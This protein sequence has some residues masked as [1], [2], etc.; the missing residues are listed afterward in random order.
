MLV[1]DLLD[2]CRSEALSD[3]GRDLNVSL[4]Q[5]ASTLAQS[6]GIESYTFA[7]D[8]E[9]VIVAWPMTVLCASHVVRVASLGDDMGEIRG[10]LVYL[11]DFKKDVFEH[12]APSAAM[13]QAPL[14]F[15]G[16]VRDF[17]VARFVKMLSATTAD[18]NAF[19][20]TASATSSA[21]GVAAWASTCDAK[22][23]V[24]M[25][26][27]EE[28]EK[29]HS[30]AALWRKHKN[31]ANEKVAMVDDHIAALNDGVSHC[32]S[33]ADAK[34]AEAGLRMTLASESARD[35]ETARKLE[36]G[37]SCAQVV[38]RRRVAR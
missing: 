7:L 26:K 10:A 8:A 20:A 16:C 9:K 14:R 38:G 6:F 21:L 30:F 23:A 2:A 17:F 35:L 15:F 22:T 24:D 12:S 4:A 11:A 27:R 33:I 31:S 32:R 36:C 25:L 29:L 1:K 34:S 37:A 5:L 18:I 13:Q 28:A 3:A 19:L